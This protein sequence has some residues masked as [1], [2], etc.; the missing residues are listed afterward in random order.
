MRHLE[1]VGSASRRSSCPPK[2]KLQT[3]AGGGRSEVSGGNC[4][5]WWSSHLPRKADCGSLRQQ[6]AASGHGSPENAARTR[7]LLVTSGALWL[8]CLNGSPAPDAR[9]LLR[10]GAPFNVITDYSKRSCFRTTEY[11][12]SGLRYPLAGGRVGSPLTKNSICQP[13]AAVCRTLNLS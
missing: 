10:S 11:G 9:E 3:T 4:G 2:S 5:E 12:L 13:K 7:V 6:R 1:A 8:S